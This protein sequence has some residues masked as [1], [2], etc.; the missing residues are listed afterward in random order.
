V[1]GASWFVKQY[2]FWAF[3]K[4]SNIYITL[5]SYPELSSSLILSYVCIWAGLKTG[6]GLVSGFTEHY[7]MSNYCAIINSHNLHFTTAC[8]SPLSLLCLPQLSGNN[9]QWQLHQLLSSHTLARRCLT[10]NSVLPHDLQQ[11]WLLCLPSIAQGLQLHSCI[12]GTQDIKSQEGLVRNFGYEY[13]NFQ[14]TPSLDVRNTSFK[15]GRVFLV[16]VCWVHFMDGSMTVTRQPF[17]L[18]RPLAFWLWWQS[19]SQKMSV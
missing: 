17:S 14:W 3:L 15:M 5:S 4:L 7:V 13:P 2:L 11:W 10:T 19:L 9:F 6:F 16:A 18:I 12:M 8:T 1:F